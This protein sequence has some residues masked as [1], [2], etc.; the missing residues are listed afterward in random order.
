MASGLSWVS[1]WV[2]MLKLHF[3]LVKIR[4][5]SIGWDFF[6][7]YK[8]FQK[9]LKSKFQASTHF[10]FFSIEVKFIHLTSLNTHGRK[11]ALKS[12]THAYSVGPRGMQSDE[13]DLTLI[14]QTFTD[15]RP[16]FTITLHL[17]VFTEVCVCLNMTWLIFRVIL[18]VSSRSQTLVIPPALK[19][20]RTRNTP[21]VNYAD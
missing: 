8:C 12:A 19:R 3:G 15:A 7:V 13:R 4:T 16:Y 2:G 18:F 11:T 14:H 10:L 5:A 9:K 6:E 17:H 21:A 1:R 20:F